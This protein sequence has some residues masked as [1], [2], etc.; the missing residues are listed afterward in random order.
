MSHGSAEWGSKGD[1]GGDVGRS[2]GG[3][4]AGDHASKTMPDEMNLPA[5]CGQSLIDGWSQTLAHQNI[6]TSCINAN[7]REVRPVPDAS[8]PM[9][10][11]SHLRVSTEKAWNEHHCRTVT[12]R[13]AKPV[14]YRCGVQQ[15]KLDAKQSLLPDRDSSFRLI[16]SKLA[17]QLSHRLPRVVR[18]KGLL[19][20]PLSGAGILDLD[21]SSKPDLREAAR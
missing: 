14:K 3:N 18:G 20:R 9:M 15:K 13:Y 2:V 10:Q 21:V 11:V 17:S 8:Q 5:G 19:T 7:A 16:L 12:V 4:G 1:D 6:R